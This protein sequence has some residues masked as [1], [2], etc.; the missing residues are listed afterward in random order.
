MKRF[1]WLVIPRKLLIDLVSRGRSAC[2]RALIFAVLGFIPSLENVYPEYSMCC[3]SKIH[4][5]R[6]NV[7]PFSDR[8][9]STWS[10]VS[11]CDLVVF[12]KINMSSAILIAPGISDN[13]VCKTCCN[14]WVCYEIEKNVGRTLDTLDGYQNA[15]INVINF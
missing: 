13:M 2:F 12:A 8:R 7:N 10:N 4:L 15:L 14:S 1:K 9:L 3:L 5:V 6:F 11:S